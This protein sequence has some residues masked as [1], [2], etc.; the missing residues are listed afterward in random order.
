MCR[1][2]RAVHTGR[3]QILAL[4]SGVKYYYHFIDGDTEARRDFCWHKTSQLVIE[5]G[6]RTGAMSVLLTAVTLESDWGLALSRQL[7]NIS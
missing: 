2:K 4:P 3:R 5:L 1:P 6:L 7:V